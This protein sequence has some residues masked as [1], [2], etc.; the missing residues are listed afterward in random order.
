MKSRI[1]LMLSTL[2]FILLAGCGKTYDKETLARIHQEQLAAIQA[3]Y[4]D[5]IKTE[6]DSF[7]SIIEEGDGPKP[8]KGQAIKAHYVGTLFDGTQFDSSYD[9]EKP[10]EVKAGVGEVIAA[11]D[12]ALLDMK[13]GEKRALYIPSKLAY[14]SSGAGRGI[15]P[16]NAIL[17]FDVELVHVQQ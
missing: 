5:A 17:V 3:K 10:L 15:I 6:A 11:W 4:P 13:Q 8:K 1:A 14:G 7:Y 12:E 2:S 16:P 9:K